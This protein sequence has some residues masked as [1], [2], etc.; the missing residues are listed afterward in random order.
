MP[1]LWAFVGHLTDEAFRYERAESSPEP[2]LRGEASG[3]EAAPRTPPTTDRARH[4]NSPP[5]VESRN[6]EL[7][8]SGAGQQLKNWRQVSV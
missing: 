4:R 2:P 5:S 1:K 8:A 7:F 6:N 3:A